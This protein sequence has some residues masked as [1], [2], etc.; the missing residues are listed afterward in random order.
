MKKVVA[1]SLLLFATVPAF[2]RA[3]EARYEDTKTF[4]F[5]P[6]S[7]LTVRALDGSIS[8]KTWRRR[9]V[10]IH[11]RKAAWGR[12]RRRA[13]E[14]LDDVEVQFHEYRDG[15]EVLVDDWRSDREMSFWDLLNPENWTS[16][17]GAKVSFE[18]TLPEDADV[19]LSADDSD[20][21]LRGVNG[22]IDIR[23]DDGDVQLQE[24]ASSELRIETDAGDVDLY[25]VDVGD[26]VLE[27][28]A[29]EGDVRVEKA[30]IGDFEAETDEGDVTVIDSKVERLAIRTDE[31]QVEL[32]VQPVGRASYRVVTEEGDVIL[33]LPRGGDY[34]FDLET[35]TGRI[36][37]EFDVEVE[38]TDT[39]E[40]VTES[41]GRGRW[42][43]RVYT[44]D[45]DIF[46]ERR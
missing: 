18:I 5:R 10:R 8:I 17:G 32:D 9:E 23:V 7:Q 19:D 14:R 34:D 15:L 35:D 12:S 21:D 45:G 40:R 6:G 11:Y 25:K 46:L 37:S 1:V 13:E 43:I 33:T 22:E 42:K 41:L 20:V 4:R 16:E 26:G 24:V 28:T 39:G 36:R 31:G 30:E 29:D 3:A 38:E 44:D 2:T 27:V